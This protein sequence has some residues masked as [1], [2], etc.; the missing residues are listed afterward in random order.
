M[1][2]V[3]NAMNKNE[4]TIGVFCDLTKA[5][6]LVPHD[7]LLMKLQKIG[8]TGLTLKW[9]E[10]YL[11]GRKQFVKVG[12]S[13]S[14][15][16]DISYGVPQGSILGPILFLI[17][18]NDLPNCT[19]LSLLLF[20]D[21]TTIL[22]SSK[23][24]PELIHLVN[25]EL[26]KI[27]CWFRSNKMSLHPEKTMFTIFCTDDRN[28]PWDQINIYID[29]NE[30]GQ[31]NPNLI[32][33]LKYVNKS[34]KVPAIKFL[35][36]YF[37]TTLSFKYH[38]DQ[39]IHKI[40]KA[41]FSIRRAKH[42]LTDKALKSLYYSTIHSHIIYAIQVYSAA[43][44]SLLKKIIL[45]QK[46]AVRC[47]SSSKYNAHT[48]PIFKQHKILPFDQLVN[49]FKV[50]FM[51]YYRN[52]DLPRSFRN[53]WQWNYERGFHELRNNTNLYVPYFRLNVINRHPICSFPRI[54]NELDDWS[55]KHLKNKNEFKVK[56]KE[57][58][59]NNLPE[60]SCNRVGC[61]SC[62]PAV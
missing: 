16:R 24:L 31:S 10:S 11:K 55:I 3:S 45:K 49:Y 43:S 4:Y 28:I 46:A 23:N 34:S 18:F 1:N 19:T 27:S 50:Q 8:I 62:T 42:I 41:I 5:F 59:L 38:I 51:L 17:F 25:H 39:L 6:D 40:S 60:F 54:W 7:I 37:D 61:T 58:L 33:P 32:K 21:D 53:V 48:V 30:E 2:N 56:Y 35:G 22:A 57:L 12:N 26:R 20:A 13:S 15:Y 52:N 44:P 29:S 14:S 47:I 9:F 36:V